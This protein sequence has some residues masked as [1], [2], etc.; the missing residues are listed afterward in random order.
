MGDV[1][2]NDLRQMGERPILATNDTDPLPLL[3]QRLRALL[4][5]PVAATPVDELFALGA[6]LHRGGDAEAALAAFE[7]CV[8]AAPAAIGGWH[9]VAALRQALGR[10]RAA[11]VACNE[12]L[13]LAP[14]DADTLFNT[15]VLLDALGEMPGARLAY[16]RA[17]QRA[18][19]HA[20]ALLNLVPLLLRERQ[21]DAA[22]RVSAQALSV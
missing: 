16:E 19:Q 15:A 13:R 5:R 10:P 2:E 7:R 12:A 21:V 6:D 17:L 18:P 20:G 9:A 14:D 22:A 1:I 8:E 11:L 4:E 3:R